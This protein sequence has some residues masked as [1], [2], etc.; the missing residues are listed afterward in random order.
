MYSWN[1]LIKGKSSMT[2]AD[3]EIKKL[4]LY[5]K[6]TKDIGITKQKNTRILIDKCKN[7]VSYDIFTVRI[8]IH[9][10]NSGYG[11]KIFDDV[12]FCNYLTKQAKQKTY[13]QFTFLY[14]IFLKKEI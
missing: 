2:K 10:N 12:I 1:L 3:K 7:L 11:S 8:S 6:N 13:A 14:E 9:L 4:Y 5:L